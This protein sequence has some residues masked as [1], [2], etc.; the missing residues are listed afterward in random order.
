MCH[1]RKEKPMRE[2]EEIDFVFIDDAKRP[3]RVMMYCGTPWLFYWHPANKWVTLRE[4]TQSET[5]ARTSWTQNKPPFTSLLP[6]LA[7]TGRRT[8]RHRSPASEN[9]KRHSPACAPYGAMLCSISP[10]KTGA[11]LLVSAYSKIAGRDVGSSQKARSLEMSR[12]DV[13]RRICGGIPFARIPVSNQC[14]EKLE[15]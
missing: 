7:F 6:T 12:V 9:R 8:N 3:Y 15:S 2:N 13:Q 5:S 14:A 11:I 10:S 1:W 4:V